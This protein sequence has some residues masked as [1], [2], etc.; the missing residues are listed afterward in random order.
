MKGI[1]SAMVMAVWMLSM[2]LLAQRGFAEDPAPGSQM[3]QL[4]TRSTEAPRVSNVF[5]ETFIT[6]ALQDIGLQAG[7]NILVDSSVQGFVTL[8]LKD[9]PLEQA[10]RLV[11]APGGYTYVKLDDKTYMVGKADKTSPIFHV[12]TKTERVRLNYVT[13][14]EARRL[15]AEYYNPYVRFDADTNTVVIT[16]APDLLDRIKADIARVDQPP[17]QVVI[18]AVVTEVSD[19]AR[20]QL[21][22]DWSWLRTPDSAQNRAF[23]GSFDTVQGLLKVTIKTPYDTLLA[24]LK[25]LVD[26]GKAQ[27][28]ANPRLT[29]LDGQSADIFVGEDRYFKIVTGSE[30]APFT[31]LE[32]IN[33]GVSLRITP[34]VARTGDI[35]LAVQPTVT[36]VTGQ[37]GDDLP[38]VSRRQLSTTVRVKDGETLVLGGLVEESRQSVTSK[39]PVLGDLP[40]IRYLFSTSRDQTT[41][42]EVVVFITPRLVSTAR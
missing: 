31:R 26:S 14:D 40:V 15:L 22:L 30:A 34:R 17:P 12:L 32:A 11:L 3:Q 13:A 10:L 36:D 33:V 6:Q 5:V 2:A 35:T 37:V 29:V 1:K 24:S 42:S 4:E 23:G 38:V 27:I 19:E 28:R 41:K 25:E 16:A 8:E 20:R 9:A 39:V 7:V 21:G 18:E